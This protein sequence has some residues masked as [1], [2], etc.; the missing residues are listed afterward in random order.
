MRENGGVND[1]S[2]GQHG[3]EIA[4]R[5]LGH[6]RD[7][8]HLAPDDLS[9]RDFIRLMAAPLA[10]AG[11]GAMAGCP[12]PREEIIP[13]VVPPELVVPGKPLFF[14]TT[15]PLAGYGIGLLAESHMGRP[16]KVEG[17]PDHPAS[18][19]A[20]DVLTQAS[21]LS[22]YD[23]DRA[24]TVTHRGQISTWSAF[25]T[26]ITGELAARRESGG[27]GIRLLT[28]AVT[29]PTLLAQIRAFLEQYPGA[30][31]HHYEPICLDAERAGTRAV[32][33]RIVNPV[34]R[35]DRARRILSLD[36]DFLL[37]GPGVVRYNRDFAAGRRVHLQG[38]DAPPAA[39]M[40]RLYAVE[41]T[42]SITGA[43]ADH[44]LAIPAG[45]VERIARL[46]LAAVRGNPPP[47]DDPHAQWVAAMADDL[48]QHRGSALAVAGPW[49]PPAVHAIAH[50]LNAELGAI[51]QTV[52]YTE[53]IEA[54]EEGDLASLTR[55]VNDMRAG[56]VDM[57]IILDANPVY[58]APADLDF[59]A[60]MDVVPLRIHLSESYDE[61][62][63]RSHWHIPLCHYLEMWSDARAFDGTAS[64]VQPLIHPLY[65][66]RSPHEFMAALLGQPEA[67]ARELLRRTWRDRAPDPQQ[68]EPFW[69]SALERGTIPDTAAPEVQV[70]VTGD[71]LAAQP[72]HPAPAD[73]LELTFR[74]DAGVFDGRFAN[75]GWLQ[76]LPK[77][78]TKLTWDNVALISPA[79]AASLG[80]TSGDVVTI[81]HAGR[82]AD[83]PVWVQP[84][85]PDNSISVQLGYGRERAGR[86]GAGVGFNAYALRTSGAMW[87]ARGVEVVP[88]GRRHALACTQP[89]QALG[90]RDIFR[91]YSL[92]QLTGEVAEE[93]A[94]KRAGHGRTVHLS[95]Y[96]PMP[97]SQINRG[98]AWGM[99]VDLNVCTGCSACVAACQ[100]E[101]NISIVGKD[102]VLAG[103]EMHWIRI[104][105][106]YKG[107]RPAADAGPYFEP[108]LCQHCQNA[109]CEYVCPV[110]ATTHSSE[111]VNEM[112]YNRCIGTRYCANNCPYKVRRFNF[113]QYA[114]HTPVRR[115]GYNPDV[116]VRTRGVMEKCTF[117]IQRINEARREEKT[118]LAR[119]GQDARARAD[120]VIDALQTACQQA[121]PT[122]AIIFG[123]LQRPSPVAALRDQPHGFAILTGL[124][125]QPRVTYLARLVNPNPAL[126][127]PHRAL[128]HPERAFH[129]E[130]KG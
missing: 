69:R 77:P 57:L 88:T 105:T 19:G 64:I 67:D 107:D 118:I 36:A 103:R 92:A 68:F 108:M 47:P 130:A 21:I 73:G 86:V 39:S 122:G 84:G 78:I 48:L 99:V 95:L 12:S 58:T 79:T 6:L 94:R 33:G 62:S 124:N 91:V 24:R 8:A 11:V 129:E 97:G 14:A 42:P 74:P 43:M 49:Q 75:N 119:G 52:V 111:G 109:P 61:T 22:L 28:G 55:L 41:S 104:D 7:L 123:D 59:S 40:H 23:P 44:R 18:L 102:Q 13:Y 45:D 32:F 35:F 27:R 34:Y 51:G 81:R 9:R 85:Q 37:F 1:N 10:L 56:A 60:A 3:G 76:E 101:N 66:S 128:D 46:T 83:A 38:A 82:Q 87:T 80:L 116:T 126:P 50:A 20:S 25:T 26:F 70:S 15:M 93:D 30:S 65:Q 4:G 100:A 53:P 121:C 127:T 29:S 89:N 114:D 98:H 16:T 112:T 31:W 63:F 17:N 71:P 90:G 2:R 96:P 106:Y 5:G 72:P 117:C 54:A 125:T 115:L 120:A 110:L 113:L